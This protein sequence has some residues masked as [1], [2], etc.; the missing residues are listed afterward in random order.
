MPNLANRGAFDALNRE[1]EAIAKQGVSP[2][3]SDAVQSV[4]TAIDYEDETLLESSFA[5][6][7]NC[8]TEVA[9]DLIGREISASENA[10]NVIRIYWRDSIDLTVSENFDEV[11]NAIES[12]IDRRIASMME[13]RD[14]LVARLNKK[15]HPIA[16]APQL[17]EAIVDLRKFR[18]SI[19]KDWPSPESQPFLPVDRKAIAEAREAIARG[20]KGLRKDQIV[21]RRAASECM[22]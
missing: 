16:N 6:L 10:K 3:L 8:L 19:L 17:D 9:R 5:S 15:D 14:K 21:W 7:L 11:K 4:L 1:L 20:E 2:L 12:L 22:A 13:I 18:E